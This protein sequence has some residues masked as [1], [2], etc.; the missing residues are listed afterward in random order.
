MVG[1]TTQN[2]KSLSEKTMTD[3]SLTTLKWYME[4]E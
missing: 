3:I 1:Y 2:N 4:V